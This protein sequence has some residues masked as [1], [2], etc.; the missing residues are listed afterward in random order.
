MP[1]NAALLAVLSSWGIGCV[2]V[3]DDSMRSAT[4]LHTGCPPAEVKIFRK[5]GVTWHATCRNKTYACQG[6]SDAQCTELVG[7]HPLASSTASAATR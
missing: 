3:S 7:M 5:R 4:A 1:R 2:T 6:G